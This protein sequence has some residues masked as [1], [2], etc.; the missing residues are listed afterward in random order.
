MHL[1]DEA[2][3]VEGIAA[4]VSAAYEQRTGEDRVLFLNARPSLNYEYVMRILDEAR[5]ETED[6]KVGMLAEG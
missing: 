2:V 3:E 5:S 4:R 6:L 1:N